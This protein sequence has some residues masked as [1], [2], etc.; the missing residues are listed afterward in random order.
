MRLSLAG[1]RYRYPSAE[2][3]TVQDIDLCAAPGE[4]LLLTGPT[5][6]GKS[7]LLRLIA[8][9][10]Q[11]HGQGDFAGEIA[12]DGVDPATAPPARRVGLA[13][14]VSQEPG[15][16]L[17]S[18]TAGDEL[19][20][21][22][23]SARRPPDAIE[24][25]IPALLWTVG[26]DIA[27]DRATS[28]L[29]GGQTQRLVTGAALSAGAGLLL[30]DEPLAQLDPGGA[31]ALLDRLAALAAGGMT[32]VM[33]EHR[34]EAALRIATRLVIM[35]E[36]RLLHDAPAADLL[37]GSDLLAGVRE[38]GLTVPGL[39]DL[40]D[41]LAPR[42]LDAQDFAPAPQPPHTP[43]GPA[44]LSATGLVHRYPGAAAAAL[45][46]V[47][48][49]LRTGERV[50]L[51]GGNGAGKSTLLGLLSGRLPGGPDLRGTVAVPQDPDLALFC[52]TVAA[53]LAYGPREA[54]LS[55][56]DLEAR[57]A[58]AADALSITDLLA[59]APQSLSR[60][61]R[62]RC[63]VAAALACRPE[64]LLLDE[65][66]S[67]QDHDQIERMMVALR[68]GLCDGVLL[69]A[70]HDVDLA[71]RHATR[72]IV[73]DRGAVIADGPPGVLAELPATVP[74][75]LPP[76]AAFCRDRGIPPAD[77]AALAAA[78]RPAPP[79]PLPAPA[80]PLAATPPPPAAP[81]R[82][83][84]LDPRTRLGLISAAGILAISLERPESLLVFALVCALPLLWVGMDRT[85]LRRGLLAVAAIIWSTVLSQGLFYAD[86]PRVSLGHLGP[87]HLYRE[88]VAY[89]L[90][91][92]MRFVGLSLAGLA[93][94]ISTPPDR[95]FAALVR[96]RVPFGLALMA[97]TALRFLPEIGREALTVRAAR[98]ARG[99]P[100][101]RRGP[102]AW[103][104][105]EV[106]LLRPIVARSWRRAQN[107]AESLDARGFD[108][109]APRSW[110]R[111]L[112]MRAADW[113]L[114]GA[115][116]AL[117]LTVA[118]ARVLYALYTAEAIYI[119]ALRPLYGFVRTWL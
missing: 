31:A 67:G 59:R 115:A 28:A 35:T 107:L 45:D 63:A 99:R 65:P 70:T 36:G 53:E 19:A 92:S 103:L 44:V 112:V 62:L 55:G 6:C 113:S 86:Q 79:R 64:V 32:V 30:L 74:I 89:G 7:T 54:G 80:V 50:A 94:A 25:A 24:A 37:P 14:F 117:S 88:G 52:P 78:A 75:T 102:A 56:A 82:P 49:T 77:A 51:L 43:P 119:P 18:G 73:L 97:A 23:E 42:A 96:L 16:Q 22:M 4:V 57:V 116:T 100:A 38:L 20:F 12:I 27:A 68:G 111:P 106:G 90:A 21:A 15:D 39:L 48:L 66:T 71:L 58:G 8:G 114:L 110:R 95:M 13:G 91:Q 61:Q 108:P 104:A 34:L 46:G 105:L 41:R 3:W 26:L 40:A 85:W 87:L 101:W 93:L 2:T 72:V 10:L 1:V 29:S 76:L 84:R 118:A 98:A 5:G 60:G 33:V 9:L 47:D 81:P 69:F 17:V 109:L 11:R 83:D